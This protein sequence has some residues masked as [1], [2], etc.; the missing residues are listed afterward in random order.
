MR[1]YVGLLYTHTPAIFFCS[2]FPA[3]VHA[4]HQPERRGIRLCDGDAER[5]AA[6]A[7]DPIGA[8]L[9]VRPG[10]PKSIGKGFLCFFDHA[11]HGRHRTGRST[12]SSRRDGP[13]PS[14][15]RRSGSSRTPFAV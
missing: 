15:S 4:V 14:S 1:I 2:S 3:F 13:T 9:P 11:P 8:P 5:D 12:E 6:S 10:N 7:S